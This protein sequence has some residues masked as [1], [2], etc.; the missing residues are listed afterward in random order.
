MSK[1]YNTMSVYPQTMRF[2]YTD[3][4]TGH[5]AHEVYH[6]TNDRYE[7]KDRLDIE[8][9]KNDNVENDNSSAEHIGHLAILAAKQA[10]K[11]FLNA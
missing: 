1:Q 4:G 9:A 10:M 3:K 6:N 2:L 7:R 11:A 5:D 8:L